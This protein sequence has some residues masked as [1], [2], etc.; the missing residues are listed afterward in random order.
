MSKHVHTILLVE[1]EPHTR[2]LIS[3]ALTSNGFNVTEAEHGQKA[4]EF[5]KEMLPDLIISDVMMPVLDGLELRR[6]IL[7]DARLTKIPFVFLSARAQTHEIIRAENSSLTLTLRNLS[8]QTR[9]CSRSGNC[10]D[11][12][13]CSD[14]TAGPR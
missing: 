1:D 5:C 3:Y 7:Q 8:S 4:L 13:C 9:S 14:T 6:R 12:N 2:R 10:L 11:K